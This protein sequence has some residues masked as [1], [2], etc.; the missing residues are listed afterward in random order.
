[1]SGSFKNREEQVHFNRCLEQQKERPQQ[2]RK[3]QMETKN[4]DYIQDAILFLYKMGYNVSNGALVDNHSSSHLTSSEDQDE[5]VVSL[6]TKGIKNVSAE[7][8]ELW[9]EEE[10]A[11]IIV[12]D[13]GYIVTLPKLVAFGH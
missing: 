7:E 10:N 9:I 12:R 5:S 11:M 4:K 2:L 1:M 13:N 3:R 6:Q 8:Y